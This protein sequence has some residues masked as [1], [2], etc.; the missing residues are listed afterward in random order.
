MKIHPY[1]NFPGN[2]EE[3]FEHYQTVFE[4]EIAGVV[5]FEDMG[6]PSNMPEAA[7]RQVAHIS[8]PLGDGA[9][10]MASDAPEGMGPPVTRGDN[11]AIMLEPDS[12]EETERLFEALSQGGTVHMALQRTDWAEKHGVCADRFGVNWMLNY[13]GGIDY[14][15]PP[16]D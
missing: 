2:A 8:M 12:A 13:T 10:L 5:R 15:L 9:M 11:V 7:R 14:Q 16:R 6:D 4:R 3:A 1:L